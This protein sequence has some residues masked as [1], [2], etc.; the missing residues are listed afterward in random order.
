MSFSYEKYKESIFRHTLVIDYNIYNASDY[1]GC[2]G[3]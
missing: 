1:C 3:E 2:I